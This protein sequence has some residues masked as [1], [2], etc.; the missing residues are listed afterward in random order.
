[1]EGFIPEEE[2]ERVFFLIPWNRS[3]WPAVR[4]DVGC[5]G[6][7]VSRKQVLSIRIRDLSHIYLLE[8]RKT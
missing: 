3:D 7:F 5:S 6:S 2:R 8:T 1:M 4:R